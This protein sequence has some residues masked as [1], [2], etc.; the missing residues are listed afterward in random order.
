M[1][2]RTALSVL[3]LV[4]TACAESIAPVEQLPASDL[5]TVPLS[6]IVDGEALVLTASLW[7]DFQPSSPP[8]G[9][10]LVAVLRVSAADGGLVPV[11]IAIDAAWVV[12]GD[13]VWATAVGEGRFAEPTPTFYEGVAR[14]GPKWG[15]GITVDVVVRV[16]SGGE[17][18]MLRAA[19]QPIH[20]TD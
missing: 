1:H 20:R 2:A 18:R 8:D 10:P 5:R 16:R 13:A 17:T 6:V 9:K 15:P 7:R 12:H 14:N 19:N 4:A 11:G 3:L